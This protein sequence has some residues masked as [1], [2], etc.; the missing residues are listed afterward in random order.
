M[1][2]QERDLDERIDQHLETGFGALERGELAAA[3]KA[4]NAVLALDATVA[5]AHTLLGGVA[6]Q[7][8]DVAAARKAYQAARSA[9]PTAFEPLLALAEIDHAEGEVARAR[10]LFAEAVEAAEEEEEFVEAVL[11]TAEFELAEGDV[12]AARAVLSELPPVELPAPNDHLRAG[13]LLR[14]IGALLSG[15]PST[16]ALAEAERHFAAAGTQAED[17][18]ALGADAL[19]GAALVAEVRGHKDAMTKNFVEVYA[20]DSKETRP[21]WGLSDARMETLVEEVLEELPERARSLLANVPI[22]I[23]ARPSR[24]QVADGM[25]PRLLGLFAG[26]SLTEG[27]DAPSL[28]QIILFTRNL[29]RAA[30]SIEDLEEEI[31]ITLLHETGHFFGLDEEALEELGLD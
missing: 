30:A 4:A 27:G 28:Q 22:V 9:D 17:D 25:D 12:D 23:E 20:L 5:E 3:K 11:A 1:A 13:D 6:E 14:Q 21:P 10:K 15:A 16:E 24:A 2:T 31:R 7:E 26:P 8:G 19:Y 29:E 18:A